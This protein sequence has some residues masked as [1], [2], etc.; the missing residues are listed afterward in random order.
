MDEN[1]IGKPATIIKKEFEEEIVK[2]INNSQLPMFVIEYVL[3]DILNNVKMAN[4]KQ[5]EFDMKDYQEKI[6]RLKNHDT[7]NIEK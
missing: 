4:Q 1:K 5:L 2:Q 6:N 7:H 3:R